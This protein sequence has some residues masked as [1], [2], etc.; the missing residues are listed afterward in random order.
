M[1]PIYQTIIDKGKGNC[2]SAAIASILEIQLDDVPHFRI[3]EDDWFSHFFDFL[4]KYDCEFRGTKYGT[5]VLSY[6][7]GIDGFYIVNGR[8]RFYVQ[9]PEIKHSVVFYKGKLV[10]DPNP[11][12]KGLYT[13]EN[14]Y[15]IEKKS[16]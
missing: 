16:K 10:H 12:N 2:L 4:I 14:C 7:K 6:E 13:I 8:S 9:D 5:D 3:L 11:A 1:I 15:M